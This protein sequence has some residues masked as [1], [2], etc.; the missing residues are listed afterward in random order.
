LEEEDLS[1]IYCILHP[2]SPVAYRA[3]ALI[4]QIT[5]QF[6]IHAAR[7][8]R[9]HQRLDDHELE[10]EDP[11]ITALESQGLVS[12]DIA[13][14]LSAAVKNRIDGG[15][16]FGRNLSRCDIVLG[17]DDEVKRVSNI[18]FRI[19]I[20]EYS[21]IMLEDQSTN[22]TIV[23]GT[24]LRAKDKENGRES[25]ITLEHG[26]VISLTVTPHEE[27][28]RF[29]VRIPQR[30]PDVQAL[31]E[32]NI[33]DYF[34]RRHNAYAARNERK[35]KDHN[36]RNAAKGLPVSSVSILTTISSDRI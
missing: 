5:P 12:C 20:N 3:T 4:H 27:D 24:L 23:D 34:M 32:R 18:H 36:A 13:L 7:D 22:G 2:C 25:K 28:F 1:D 30:D 14:R 29:I 19:Y 10:N 17:R 9:I 15:F 16:Y 6:T 11:A 8:V 35:A 33:N 21:V 31:Y 26:S